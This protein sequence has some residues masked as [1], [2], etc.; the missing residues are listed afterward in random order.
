MDSNA[1]TDQHLGGST[2]GSIIARSDNFILVADDQAL[3]V[4]LTAVGGTGTT[5]VQTCSI[6]PPGPAR[7]PATISLTDGD[8]IIVTCGSFTGETL[9]GPVTVSIG[10]NIDVSIPAGA[11]ALIEELPGAVLSISNVGGTGAPDIEINDNGNITNRGADEPPL[12]TILTVVVNG[13]DSGVANDVLPGGASIAELVTDAFNL[14]GD[15]AVDDLLE[16]L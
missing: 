7:R 2:F 4:S 11:I 14:G 15:D 9:V 13:C 10:M 6:G 8:Q 3:G 16:D 1:F 12:V 5:Q